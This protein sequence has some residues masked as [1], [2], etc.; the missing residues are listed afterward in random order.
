T[1]FGGCPS[2]TTVTYDT[3]RLHY[4]EI[5]LRGVFHFTPADV[6]AAF[7]ALK[8]RRLMADRFISGSYALEDLAT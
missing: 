8:N 2:G 1:L 6:K 3:H 4:D 5:T 7:D